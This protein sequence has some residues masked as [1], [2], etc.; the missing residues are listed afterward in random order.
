MSTR[1]VPNPSGIKAA[2]STPE[3]FAATKKIADGIAAKANGMAEANMLHGER[4]EL[5]AYVAH[6]GADS[7]VGISN[8][9]TASYIGRLDNSKNHTLQKAGGV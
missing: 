3:C 9:S 6:R 7:D 1:F 5:P 8:V 2:F 4:L